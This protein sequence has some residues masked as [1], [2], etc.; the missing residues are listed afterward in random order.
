[1]NDPIIVVGAGPVGLTVA[2]ELARRGVP[3]R[4]IDKLEEPTDESRAILVH[5]RSLEMF[6]TI[7][8]VEELIAAGVRTDAMEL[9]SEGRTVA[10][11]GFGVVDS[12]FPY[13]VTIAQTDTERILTEALARHGVTVDRGVTL[14]GLDQDASGVRARV[15]R[16]DGSEDVLAG[17][18][19]VGADGAH[20]DVRHLVGS[21]LAGSFTGERFLM[22]D[23]HAAH[24]LDPHTMYTY[25][26][27]HDGPLLAF[28]M[29]G[30][31][32]RLIAQVPS[33]AVGPATQ[34]WLQEVVDQRSDRRLR[35]KDSLWLTTFEVHHAQV[36]QYRVGRVFLAGDAAHVHSPAGGQGMN[37]GTQDA[38]NLGWK[39]A[40]AAGTQAAEGRALLDSYHAERHP[41]GAK[42]IEF[43]TDLTRVGAF[44]SPVA[45][46]LRNGAMHAMTALAPV[47][48]A[49]ADKVEETALS[50]RDS[51]L[52]VPSGDRAH[53]AAGDHLPTHH[54]GVRAALADGKDHVLLTLAPGS[55]TP[56]AAASGFRQIL[57][58]ADDAER[59]GY[60]TVVAD[61]AAVVAIH[62]GLTGGGRVLVRPD[63]Y[64]GAVITLGNDA[65]LRVYEALLLS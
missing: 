37:T 10:R 36:P 49:L 33:D 62:L 16:P 8:V 57:V 63:G 61:P 30:D 25:F 48:L 11:V 65:P 18:W 58:T 59:D 40:L 53:L 23:V 46:K 17:S 13:S 2:G 34:E 64:V 50:Y 1:M 43:T 27:R 51:P 52:V 35:I 47:R 60:D 54:P 39:L 15:R 38:F 4:V 31:R 56:A 24:D 19:L 29:K 55:E 42:V 20:S 14:T 6:E 28:P 9:R 45:Q 21:A 3:V 12:P 41:V 5:A 32:M 22:G 26:S 44:T 7:G